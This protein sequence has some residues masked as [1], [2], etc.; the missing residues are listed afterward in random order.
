[1][2]RSLFVALLVLL[3]APAFGQTVN[4][5]FVE[6]QS[7]DHSIV[8]RYE[9]GYFLVGATSPVTTVSLPQAEWASQPDAYWRHALPRPVLGN[10][11]AKAQAWAPIPPAAGG[12]EIGSGW[13][14]PTGPFSLS[15]LAPVGLRTP[16]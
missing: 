4:P 11:V 7:A 5:R 2:K 12:G 10:Y 1:V 6:F 14:D 15:P 16:Q 9:I 13:S 8:T 3:A